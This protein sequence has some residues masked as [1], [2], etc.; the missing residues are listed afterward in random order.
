MLSTISGQHVSTTK[1]TK[2]ILDD[3]RQNLDISRMSYG[4]TKDVITDTDRPE[5]RRNTNST[6]SSDNSCQTELSKCSLGTSPSSVVKSTL[7]LSSLK[8]S[9]TSSSPQQGIEPDLHIFNPTPP[10][11]LICSTTMF[12]SIDNVV[13]TSSPNADTQT[14]Y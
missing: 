5:S 10:P 12:N 3:Q 1:S 4:D 11:T 6:N 8:T 14:R 9:E 13:T 7:D 2:E